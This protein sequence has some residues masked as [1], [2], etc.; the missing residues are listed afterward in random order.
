MSS[1]SYE[2]EN[3]FL[4]HRI[5]HKNDENDE[6][7]SARHRGERMHRKAIELKF[8]LKIYY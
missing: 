6:L 8:V 7:T 3:S 4:R 1:G 5:N 2:Q